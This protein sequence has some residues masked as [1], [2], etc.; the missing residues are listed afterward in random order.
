M[1]PTALTLAFLGGLL[2]AACGGEPRSRSSNDTPAR[3]GR[4]FIQATGMVKSLGIT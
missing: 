4:L 1:H 3:G 2:M